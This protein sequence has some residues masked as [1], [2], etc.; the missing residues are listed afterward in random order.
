MS[1]YEIKQLEDYIV[2]ELLLI[3][4][5]IDNVNY[6][7]HWHC[8]CENNGSDIV[9]VICKKLENRISNV[10]SRQLLGG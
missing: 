1:R 8:C 3:L 4:F 2:N 5:V 9:V 10:L 7:E 6:H